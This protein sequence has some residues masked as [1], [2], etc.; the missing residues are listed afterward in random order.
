MPQSA[1]ICNPPCVTCKIASGV[2][3]LNC[4]G[5]GTTSTF[6]PE[7]PE[8][9]ILRNCSRRVRIRQRKQIEGSEVT[10]SRSR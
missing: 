3:S 4:T 9:R 2:R 8:G 5:P 6:V 1:S 10:K 7:S